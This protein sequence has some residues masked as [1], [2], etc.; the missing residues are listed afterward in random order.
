MEVINEVMNLAEQFTYRDFIDL[1]YKKDDKGFIT[2]FRKGLRGKIYQKHFKENTIAAELDFCF[3]KDYTTDLYTSINTFIAPERTIEK[4]RYLNAL[5]IDI[6]CYKLNLRKESVVYFL[7]N[8]FY[9]SVIPE[10]TLVVESGRGLTLYWKINSVPSK[11]LTLWKA[12]Q[13]FLYK[14]LKEFGAD[15]N[16]LDP[17]RIFRV[18]GSCNTKSFTDVKVIEYNKHNI[19]DLKWLKEN[20]LPKVEKKKYIKKPFKGKIVR[21]FNKY[22]L[23]LARLK[24]LETLAELRNYD[25]DTREVFLFLYRYYAEYLEGKE[26]ALEMTLELNSKF[27]RPLSIG[28]VRSSTKS[29]YIGKYNYSNSKLIEMFNISEEEQL[30]LTTIHSK[31]LKLERYNESRR[32]KRRNEEGLTSREQ[33]KLDKL[34]SIFKG[35]KKELKNKEI[36]EVLNVTVRLV[37][38]YKK[39]ISENKELHLKLQNMYEIELKKLEEAEKN[40]VEKLLISHVKI[41]TSK[42]VDEVNYFEELNK[43]PAIDINFE[44]T[45]T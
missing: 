4:L 3:E 27:I 29:N 45:G 38:K 25:L 22:T 31:T 1:M 36:A 43:S 37:Q 33:D 7:E 44:K 42:N 35:L 10:P 24:D 21:V 9:G 12:M 39:E 6:D 28:E 19:Y 2:V 15:I 11:A 17:S 8:D 34:Y 30:H 5:Y 18:I 40:N 32:S 13:Y 14:E 26:K 16:A 23:E 20:Y 41:S